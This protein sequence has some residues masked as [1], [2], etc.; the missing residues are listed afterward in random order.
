MLSF[1]ERIKDK[2]NRWLK[3]SIKQIHKVI[4]A[5]NYAYVLDDEDDGFRNEVLN[6]LVNQWK[7]MELELAGRRGRL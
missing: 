3:N 1:E 5:F 7:T 6:R 4:C 2:P